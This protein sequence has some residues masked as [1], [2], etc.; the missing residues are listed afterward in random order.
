MVDQP[1][2]TRPAL[3]GRL[4]AVL[5]PDGVPANQVERLGETVLH[6][7]I[8]AGA[9]RGQPLAVPL[10]AHFPDR[11]PVEPECAS[12]PAEPTAAPT[13]E[14]DHVVTVE[15]DPGHALVTRRKNGTKAGIDWDNEP[16]LGKMPDLALAKLRGVAATTVYEVRQRRKIPPF[17]PRTTERAPGPRP[18]KGRG[19]WPA[20]VD[21]DN[22]PR[23]GQMPD[24]A[25]GKLLGVTGTRVSQ[26]RRARKI[27]AHRESVPAAEAKPA[28][29]AKKPTAKPT[30]KPAPEAKP[31]PESRPAPEAKPTPESK[32]T[33]APAPEPTPEPEPAFEAKPTPPAAPEPAPVPKCRRPSLFGALQPHE[34]AAGK[35]LALDDEPM[36]KRPK[37]RAE[38]AGGPRPCPWVSCR[39]HLAIDVQETQDGR[40]SIAL[41]FGHLDLEAMPETCSLDVAD[42]GEHI[43]D[44]VGRAL[45]GVTRERIRQIEQD[46]LKRSRKR[47][48]GAALDWFGDD[49]GGTD[50]EEALA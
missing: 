28:P 14:R 5:F 48:P 6:L 45:G 36:P 29:A 22:E 18:P 17:D 4:L 13:P 12:P 43:L 27:S 8:A 39:H 9:A 40:G 50:P 26:V 38:C 37:T 16:R 42:R 33:P 30:A 19:G 11:T 23:L 10:V 24:G 2:V 31:T 7:D 1:I 3:V 49:E 46:A 32:P 20:K 47:I 25:L 21:W 35:A 41:A 15:V 34:I 44:D